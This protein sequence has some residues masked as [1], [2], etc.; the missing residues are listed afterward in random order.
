MSGR[1]AT[2]RAA[3]LRNARAKAAKVRL[4]ILADIAVAFAAH[5]ADMLTL[6]EAAEAY[7]RTQSRG[8]P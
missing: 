7:A 1:S 6:A 8:A 2:E 3:K 4:A 5:E